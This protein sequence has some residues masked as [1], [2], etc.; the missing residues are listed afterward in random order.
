MEIT[1]VVGCTNACRYC[2]QDVLAKQYAKRPEAACHTV[3]RLTD[4]KTCLSRI[5]VFVRIHFSGMAEPWLNPDCMSMIL[6]AHQRGYI[7]SVYTTAVGM[8]ARDIIH[9]ERIP[10]SHFAIHLPGDDGRT[11][12]PSDQ[13]AIRKLQML[14]RRGIAGL[15]F[16]SIGPPHPAIRAALKSP[17]REMRVYRRAGNLVSDRLEGLTPKKQGF[18]P[19]RILRGE[20][21][22]SRVEGMLLDRNVLLPNGDVLLC[23]MD[24]GLKHIVGNLLETSYAQLFQSSEYRRVQDGLVYDSDI[25]CRFCEAAEPQ[26]GES[27]P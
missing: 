26:H 12:S 19:R 21:R 18:S 23:C 13:V 20:I 8:S 14:E 5:P 16:R 17:I 27:A 4:F 10:F 6:H 2:P 1:T 24:Y 15:Q 7:L 9:L 3:M 11:R 22:C 25:I